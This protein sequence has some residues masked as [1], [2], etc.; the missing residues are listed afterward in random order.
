MDSIEL[1]DIKNF[2]QKFKLGNILGEGSFGR[3]LMAKHLQSGKDVAVKFGK[4]SESLD[5]EY[6]IYELIK[7][8]DSTL[9]SIKPIP[10]IYGYGNIG[11]LTWLAME[12]CGPSINQMFDKLGSFTN[13]TILMLGIEMVKCIDYLHRCNIVHGDIKG[14]NFAISATNPRKIMIFDFGLARDSSSTVAEFHGSLLYASIATHEYR[15]IHPKDDIESLGYLI[16]D[17]YKALP[18]KNTKWPESWDDQVKYGLE[19]KKQKNIFEMSAGFF[20]I[21]LFLMHVDA[22]SKPNCEYLKQMFR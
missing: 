8:R 22:N 21:A 9:F 16:S 14:D 1:E 13:K 17:L 12:L 10:M 2:S 15:A 4:R 6:K 11:S 19:Q 7:I 18:W 5:Y 3:V 20:E